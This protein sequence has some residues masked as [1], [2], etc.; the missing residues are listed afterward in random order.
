VGAQASFEGSTARP[1]FE[2]AGRTIAK[3]YGI[4]KS[5]AVERVLGRPAC[6][7]VSLLHMDD[8]IEL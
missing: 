5:I 8:E 2:G 3:E 7:T 6:G 1:Y 4:S